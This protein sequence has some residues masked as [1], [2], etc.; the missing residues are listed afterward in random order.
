MDED[1]L[2]ELNKKSLTT[3]DRYDTFGA[4]AQADA[5]A[6][7]RRDAD[8]RAAAGSTAPSLV[9]PDLLKPVADSIG[10]RLLQ[11]M[12]WRQVRCCR[13]CDSLVC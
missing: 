1:E 8:S 6:G 10:I 2:A 7:A 5:E 3:A 9:P 12:G 11:K 4:R 13:P